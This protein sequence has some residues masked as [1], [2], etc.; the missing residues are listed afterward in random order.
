MGTPMMC[1]ERCLDHSGFNYDDSE[2]FDCQPQR[3]GNAANPADLWQQFFRALNP[4]APRNIGAEQEPSQRIKH[5][6]QDQ[7]IG[8]PVK[9]YE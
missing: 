4:A 7:A 9:I 1:S 3:Q 6:G 5:P 8:D 2:A